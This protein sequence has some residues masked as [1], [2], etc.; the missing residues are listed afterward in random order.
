M[1]APSSPLTSSFSS[2][3]T[4]NAAAEYWSRVVAIADLARSSADA[5]ALDPIIVIPMVSG[6]TYMLRGKIFW[7]AEGG[8]PSLNHRLNGPAF[9]LLNIDRGIASGVQTTGNLTPSQT[10]RMA[11][12][13][14]DVATVWNTGGP[15]Q[16]FGWIE[17][18]GYISTSAAGNFGIEWNGSVAL[19]WSLTRRKGSYLEYRKLP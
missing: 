6:A 11:Y 2:G 13:V 5:R 14:A 19:P 12:D 3:F 10:C 1:G 18:V 8:G 4:R 16:A 7:T 9:S 15:A 17:I